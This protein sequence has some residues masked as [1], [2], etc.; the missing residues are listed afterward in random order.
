MKALTRSIK[1][2]QTKIFTLCFFL[3]ITLLSTSKV[4]AQYDIN[5]TTIVRQ[6]VSPF[7]MNLANTDGSLNMT[8]ATNDLVN[9]LSVILRNTGNQQRAV[10]LHVKIERISPSPMSISIKDSYQPQ[11]PIILQPNQTL[12][13]SPNL[14]EEA[15]GGF[16]KNNLRFDNISLS[17]LRSNGVNYK[18]PEG[19]YRFCVTAYDYN[20]PGQ[21]MPLSAPGTG[22]ANFRICYSA[23]A[24]QFL[25][26]VSSMQSFNND[27]EEVVPTSSQIQF[28]WTPPTTT[29]GLPMGALN[30]DLEIREMY[31]G[32]TITDGINNPPVFEKHNI[33]TT[34]FMLDTLRFPNVLRKNQKYIVRVKADL[35]QQMNNPLTIDNDGYSELIG[36]IYKPEENSVEVSEDVIS[37]VE[38]EDNELG[39]KRITGTLSW[40]FRESEENYEPPSTPISIHTP[41]ASSPQ[42]SV[43]TLSVTPVGQYV[44]TNAFNQNNYYALTAEDPTL[45]IT[46]GYDL[47]VAGSTNY[48]EIG[49]GILDSDFGEWEVSVSSSGAHTIN[50][51]QIIESTKKGRQ[52]YP[53]EGA[54][55]QLKMAKST[56]ESI[57]SDVTISTVP[58]SQNQPVTAIGGRTLNSWG[59]YVSESELVATPPSGQLNVAETPNTT[60]IVDAFM[61]AESTTETGDEWQVIATA[62]TTA[63]GSFTLDYV[64]EEFLESMQGEELMISVNHPGFYK[65][66]QKI[67]SSEINQSSRE[68]DLGE[69]TLV[70]N[71][72]RF[73]PSVKDVLKAT[74]GFPMEELKIDI[75]R[76]ASLYSSNK[77]LEQEGNLNSGSQETKTFNGKQYHKV[78]SGVVSE[79]GDDWKTLK[80]DQL[81]AFDKF[82]IEITSEGTGLK[83]LTT[84]LR[85]KTPDKL[86]IKLADVYAEYEQTFER[87]SIEGRVV[88]GLDGNDVSVP[89]AVI[90]VSYQKSDVDG[91]TYEEEQEVIYNLGN[92]DD[93]VSIG[94]EPQNPDG[95]YMIQD[96]YIYTTEHSSHGRTSPSVVTTFTTE[97]GTVA[98]ESEALEVSNTNEIWMEDYGDNYDDMYENILTGSKTVT[99][100][101]SGFFY[102]DNLPNLKDGAQYTV[103][104]ESVPNAYKD[105]PVD[106]QDKSMDIL[107]NPGS[108]P[109]KKFKLIPE[110]TPIIGKVLNEDG[111]ALPFAKLHFENSD[112][113]FETNESGIFQTTHFPGSHTL[114]VEKNGYVKKE[115]TLVIESGEATVSPPL[116]TEEVASSEV[117]VGDSSDQNFFRNYTRALMSTESGTDLEIE[118]IQSPQV[119][120]GFS[121]G[122]FDL[123]PNEETPTQTISDIIDV[124]DIGF[125]ERKRA[126]IQFIV[127]D[128]DTDEPIENVKIAVFDTINH[129]N[130]EGKWFYEGFGGNTI[131]TMSPPENSQYV[132]KQFE[133]DFPENNETVEEVFYL[134]KGVRV[135]GQATIA[136]SSQAIDSLRIRVVDKEFIETYTNENGD[137]EFYVPHDELT[138]KASKVGFVAAEETHEFIDD[139]VEINF[140]LQDGGDKNISQLLGFDIE[141]SEV[142]ENDDGSQTWTGEFVN[143][144]FFL[145]IIKLDNESNLDFTDIKVTFD[146]E[147]NAIPESGEVA[148]NKSNLEANLFEYIPVKFENKNETQIIVKKDENG[149]WGSIS[150]HI[151]LDPFRII[152]H[153]TSRE[154]LESFAPT[155]LPDI[156]SGAMDESTP[157]S[158]EFFMGEGADRLPSIGVEN[159]NALKQWLTDQGVPVAEIENSANNIQNYK[160]EL[161]NLKFYFSDAYSE[162]VEINVYDFELILDTENSWVS[163]QGLNLSGE[164]NTPEIGPLEPLELPV[165]ELSFDTAFELSNLQIEIDD[166]PALEFGESLRAH[167]NQLEISENG[168]TTGGIVTLSLPSS[169]PSYLKLTDLKISTNGISGGQFSFSLDGLKQE[170]KQKAKTAANDTRER[171]KEE[172]PAFGVAIIKDNGSSLSFGQMSGTGAYYLSGG[173]DMEFTKYIKKKVK[174]NNFM[175][176]TDGDFTIDVPTDYAADFGFAS[177][178]LNAIEVRYI[179]GL[180]ALSLDGGFDVNF[181]IISFEASDI[182]FKATESGDANV[183]IDSINASLDVPGINAD[184]TLDV[185]AN[186][187]GDEGFS[188]EGGFEIPGTDFGTEI[189]FHYYK[190]PSSV[191]VGASFKANATIPLGGVVSLTSLGGGFNYKKE[192]YQ[193][194][195]KIH[196]ESGVAITGTGDIIKIDPLK[197]EV[198]TGSSS[199]PVIKGQGSI[200]VAN[201]INL[202][203]TDMTLDLNQKYFAI[204]ID[205]QFEPING[206]TGRGIGLGRVSWKDDFYVFIGAKATFNVAGFLDVNGV[207]AFGY[208]IKPSVRNS[209]DISPFF[210]NENIDEKT[211]GRNDNF[212]GVF[213]GAG[214]DFSTG[215]LGGDIWIASV[216]GSFSSKTSAFF[217][218][219]FPTTSARDAN[220]KVSLTGDIYGMVKVSALDQNLAKIE[221]NAC[222]RFTGGYNNEVGWNIYGKVAVGIEASI[223]S[224]PNECN[225]IKWKFIPVG[226]RICGYADVSIEYKQRGSKPGFDFS[227]SLG[228]SDNLKE[229]DCN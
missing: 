222:Y 65:F 109:F 175:V 63:D 82:Y 72:F 19:Q 6:P 207:F 190:G 214:T 70:A 31:P 35:M 119:E 83:P 32:Q 188:G 132:A 177:Y 67:T 170:I 28:S 150:G 41:I 147:G 15:F 196:I 216:Y 193:Y 46:A 221:G 76:E 217:F 85:V 49:S 86:D 56:I 152:S 148:I 133:V 62:V 30:Y 189:A 50:Y 52:K 129:T 17:E 102:V 211:L 101:E 111:D 100:D 95:G 121:A 183:D 179:Q 192:N 210:D 160:N 34:T 225:S 123:P 185:G 107:V 96:P 103:T 68:I 45:D 91:L 48:E 26:P 164:I 141:L 47:N 97:T 113:Y 198:E 117:S 99:T 92:N 163:Q 149:S 69:L 158:I 2:Y 125:L 74:T 205:A 169:E 153:E 174:I 146:D 122:I 206:I 54:T 105:M 224:A 44:G 75:Y 7:L 98:Y 77:F 116:V 43:E 203:E 89:G 145:P 128:E 131:V 37:E 136:N 140:E 90:K 186:D 40:A 159:E 21:S 114:I 87:P 93:Q 165:E 81:F 8:A 24:P 213:V 223:L 215:R 59:A 27:F 166:L 39:D 115:G 38:E 137:Y 84:N 53:L 178:N 195:V 78:S 130:A 22:C 144:N 108:T 9:N 55:I 73:S 29:C 229:M 36:I 138:L 11:S 94:N 112:S 157:G 143:L 184:V 71:T 191:D 200:E 88:V 219:N 135:F 66:S 154:M 181:N 220:F 202:V 182:V 60:E 124:G 168:I 14:I 134:K 104:L 171:I 33:P 212:N 1:H 180:P 228:K 120:Y 226:A 194:K 208:N 199:H 57:E 5:V 156:V 13:L 176:S 197:V 139:D 64:N 58:A 79:N 209:S 167:V 3:F 51:E 151:S 118:G 61:N 16:S 201:S 4:Q 204:T 106:P 172:I 23:S 127:K 155:I 110:I 126:K 20:Q 142:E 25:M 227:G 12:Q 218:L 162:D 187:N 42:I 10:K 18:L 161:K 173:V 80:F